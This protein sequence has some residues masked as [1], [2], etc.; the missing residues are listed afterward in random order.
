M[1][2]KFGADPDCQC[3]RGHNPFGWFWSP[4]MQRVH[5]ERKAQRQQEPEPRE[6]PPDK[7]LSLKEL[8]GVRM[9]NK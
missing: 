5:D 4:E 7:V 1:A 6:Q 3:G 8:F 2:S 9:R